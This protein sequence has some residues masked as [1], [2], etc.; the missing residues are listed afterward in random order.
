MA[1]ETARRQ[2]SLSS[3][4]K[5]SYGT[6]APRPR[7][8]AETGLTETFL[9]G[10][11]SKH[12]LDHGT[13][14]VA[15]LV[16]RMALAGP[17]I[18]ELLGRLRRGAYVEVRAAANE[19]GALRY[20]LTDRGRAFALEA[21]T[22]SG[23]V[24]PAP[25]PLEQ[26]VKIVKAQSVHHHGVT[27]PAMHAAF[28]DTV[29]D[30]Q[31]LDAI[32]A[33]LN[34][35]RGIFIYGPAGSGKTYIC[36]R[37]ARILGEPVLVPYAIA[38]ASEPVQLFDPIIHCPVEIESNQRTVRLEEGFDPRYVLCQRPAVTTGGELTLDMLEISH[39]HAAKLHNAP[40]QLKA[41]NGIYLID[42]LGRQRVQPIDL[43][44]RWIVPLEN[45]V[46]YLTLASG[47]RF[48]VPFDVILL[49]STNLN[50]K[51]L[52]D[53]A[54]LRR[55][56]HK[57]P[58]GYQEPDAYAAIWQQVCAERGVQF[59]RALVDYAV[60]ELHRKH[61][62]PLLACHPRDL[63]GLALD[64][65]RYHTGHSDITPQLLDIAW[66]EYF[67]KLDDAPGDDNLVREN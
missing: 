47:K 13:S 65:A 34:S 20:A 8:V 25:V 38:V 52:S 30:R 35:G 62:M 48:P 40:L 60:N 39:D 3:D 49:F 54:F 45:R 58:F 11:T 46:D 36:Q 27:A 66:Q 2:E 37:L 15:E 19:A 5:T 64:H 9:E 12:L 41:T 23:Y 51:K 28:E 6:L 22:A 43:F 24:G 18:E 57:I 42:D 53:A 1:N 50:P 63:I 55:L 32:G 21:L 17:V 59:D 61:R 31:L 14:T 4:A 33:A 7:T 44:N 29:I 10:L 67:V 26:Y 16:N 56:G